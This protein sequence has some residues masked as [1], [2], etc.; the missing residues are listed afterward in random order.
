[1]HFVMRIKGKTGAEIDII[2][3][4]DLDLTLYVKSP[5]SSQAIPFVFDDNEQI[6]LLKDWLSICVEIIEGEVSNV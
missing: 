5:I 2:L 4:G 3:G 6:K 1:M